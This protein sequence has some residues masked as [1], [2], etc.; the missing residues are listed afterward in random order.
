MAESERRAARLLGLGLVLGGAGSFFLGGAECSGMAACHGRLEPHKEQRGVIYSPSWP[1]NY[2]PSMNCS[3]YIQ[4][5]YGDLITISFQNFEL[6]NSHKC[7]VDWL[8]VGPAPMR[9]EYRMCGSYIP[10][11]FISTRD[12]AWVFFHSH[13]SSSG[14]SRGFRLSYIR[15][16]LAQSSCKA[17]E[18]LCGN[19]KCILSAWRCNQ[20]DECGDNSDEQECQAPATVPQASL[21][22]AGTFGCLV[23]RA[24]LC[25]PLAVRCDGSADCEEGA[26]EE[27]CPDTSCGK[28][29]GNFYGSF[30]SPDYFR[31]ARGAAQLDCT[32]V[33][34]TQDSRRIVLQLSLQ[35]GYSDRLR[36][37]DGAAPERG[38]LLQ[39]LSFRN[40]R[41]PVTL[42]SSR[43]QIA[44]SYRTE[45]GS[46]GHGFNATYQVKGYCLP[47]QRP[48]GND[49]GCF[50]D[51]QRCDGW[52]QCPD[53]KDEESCAACQKDEYPC[54][55][56][57][58]MCYPPAD[59][60]NNQKNC[61]D[62]SDEKNCF[63]CQPGNFHCGTKICIFEQ[64]RCDGQED[65]Q[66][67]SDE[68]HCLVVVPRK[69]ITAALIGSLICG[70]LLVIALGC[71]FKLYSLRTREYRA[72][73]TPMTRLEADFVQRE[74][75]PSYG[76][77]IAQGL[78][79]PVDDFPVYNPAQA[80]V[81]QNIRTAMRRQIRRH[82]T[83]RMTSRGRLSRIW[84]R[85]FHRPRGW[86][87]IPLLTPTSAS[88]STRL[89]RGETARGCPREEG[90]RSSAGPR[91]EPDSDTDTE[92]DRQVGEAR[93]AA[94]DGLPTAPLENPVLKSSPSPSPAADCQTGLQTARPLCS[95]SSEE[96][97][98]SDLDFPLEWASGEARPRDLFPRHPLSGSPERG[99]GSP[100]QRPCSRPSGSGGSR[101]R[102][103]GV[104]E[105]TALERGQAGCSPPDRR[106]DPNRQRLTSAPPARRSQCCRRPDSVTERPCSLSVPRHK[107]FSAETPPSDPSFPNP[108]RQPTH[109]GDDEALLDC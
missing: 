26:D 94:G 7:T 55:G 9:E 52:W 69:V 88:S 65:C 59:R 27:S 106:R 96:T 6:E 11:P 109:R 21:C 19:G 100:R 66:D 83:R 13:R 105:V 53:G 92:T 1:T 8:M 80:S 28:R 39:T 99:F 107:H 87:L 32:W 61:P 73:D 3:W 58:G 49:G 51:A 81:L 12:H 50:A 93:G 86:G 31:P 34:D 38:R 71:A 103:S 68:H 108:F 62:G 90:G 20:M 18:F 2:P 91:E 14:R 29:L 40:N 16:K 46:S 63:S 44:V 74:A 23:E 70:L 101:A 104:V 76:Q 95:S 24:P 78:I 35:L 67:G 17:D 72:F 45:P 54:G 102:S 42:E 4:G 10:Q 43:G 47:R 41:R 85:F 48:C 82:S 15:G 30:A 98:S 64:W 33:V 56:T 97:C 36:V 77:L 89:G 22:P 84:N 5:G 37:Y 57:S 25:L 60:C 75:P 79:P